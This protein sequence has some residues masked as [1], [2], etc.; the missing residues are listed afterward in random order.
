MYH[1][2][3][4]VS[5]RDRILLG[6]LLFFYHRGRPGCSYRKCIPYAKRPVCF[7]LPG[8]VNEM[9]RFPPLISCPTSLQKTLHDA[10]EK[11]TG[12]QQKVKELQIK[13]AKL[14]AELDEANRTKQ[15]AEAVVAKGK[16]KLDLAQRLIKAL[17]SENVRWNKGVQQLKE[18]RMA[19][20]GDSLLSAAFISYI[21]PFAK[22]YRDQLVVPSRN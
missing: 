18:S 5:I 11:L 12:V 9:T 16:M 1:S 7:V 14:V 21:G 8:V 22:E 6:M 10:N 4:P 17:S 19:L 3:H 15:E 13:L 20:I 2:A